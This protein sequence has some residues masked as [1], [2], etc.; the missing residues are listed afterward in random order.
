MPV[1]SLPTATAS[2]RPTTIPMT[3][4]VG[5]L[6]VAAPPAASHRPSPAPSAHPAVDCN[7]PYYFNAQGDRLFKKECL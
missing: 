7:P 4:P 6:P 1:T 5:Q 3:V 2:G